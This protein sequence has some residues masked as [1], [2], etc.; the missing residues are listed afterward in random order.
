MK[1]SDAFAMCAIAVLAVPTLSANQMVEEPISTSAKALAISQCVNAQSPHKVKRSE[2]CKQH[3]VKVAKPTYK[4]PR[5]GRA[6]QTIGGATRSATDPLPE[7][8]VLAP[9]DHTGLTRDDQPTLYWFISAQT[10]VPIEF[11]LIDEEG[12]EPEPLIE[13]RLPRPIAA[14]LHQIRL[15]DYGV[16]L[17]KGVEYTWSIALVPDPEHP[18]KD[19]VA[20]AGIARVDPSG[21][22]ISDVI[23][24]S[25]T[26]IPGVYAE[27]GLWYDALSTLSSLIAAET[28]N[29]SS[30]KNQ[31]AT[32]LGQIHLQQ[33]AAYD[34]R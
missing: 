15:V 22:L 20:Q 31:R 29:K 10:T 23:H 5:M 19:V 27:A 33:V 2:T 12:D 32:L 21:Q 7:I 24:A 4:P 26:A 11:T 16:R 1:A 17:T 25:K 3:F 9:N 34:R 8:A 6:W 13:S 18:S 28:K 30:L 14:G